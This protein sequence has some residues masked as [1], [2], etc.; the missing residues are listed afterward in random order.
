MLEELDF[1][2][3][4]KA[5]A[6]K[7]GRAIEISVLSSAYEKMLALVDSYNT[8]VGWHGLVNI[9]SGKDKI[10]ALLEDIIVYPQVTTFFTVKTDEEIYSNWIKALDDK[11][12][13]AINMQGHSHVYFNTKPSRQDIEYYKAQI[14]N[15]RDDYI[16]VIMNKNKDELWMYFCE[17]E[18]KLYQIE[19][20]NIIV[21]L[22]KDID[23]WLK[24]NKINIIKDINC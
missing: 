22:V 18:K 8:E 21:D 17:D 12:Y 4:T 2:K 9:R 6:N 20:V 15:F 13:K 16:F 7:S 11:I 5:S 1:R 19:K 10:E 23:I 24:N 3:P 14:E